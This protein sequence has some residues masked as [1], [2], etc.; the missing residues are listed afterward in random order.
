MIHNNYGHEGI[1][2]KNFEDFII[3]LGSGDDKVLVGAYGESFIDTGAG[4]DYVLIGL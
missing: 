2:L 1:H 3:R 4:D